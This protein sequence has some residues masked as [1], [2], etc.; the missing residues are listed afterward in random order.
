MA[1]SAMLHAATVAYRV[2]AWPHADCKPDLAS[3]ARRQ[4]SH[5]ADC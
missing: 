3:A 1:S 2:A 4:H 5:E